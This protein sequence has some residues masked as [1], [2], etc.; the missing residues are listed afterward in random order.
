MI[1][2]FLTPRKV[3]LVL[4]ETKRHLPKIKFRGVK[5]Q[6]GKTSVSNSKRKNK[7]KVLYSKHQQIKP[8]KIRQIWKTWAWEP[9]VTL[10]GMKQTWFNYANESKVWIKTLTTKSLKRYVFLK[11]PLIPFG[12]KKLKWISKFKF[13]RGFWKWTE[14]CQL[15]SKLEKMKIIFWISSHELR[16]W[17]N[18]TNRTSGLNF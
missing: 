18:T 6:G 9:G 3:L 10:S 5:A 8:P 13:T 4:D 14:S 16:Q 12:E 15:N 2:L 1:P 17:Q 11:D 7:T